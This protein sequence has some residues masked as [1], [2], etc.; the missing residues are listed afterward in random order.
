MSRAWA[1]TGEDPISITAKS[2]T[3]RNAENRII[4]EGDVRLERDGF[5]LKADR[6]E[7][8]LTPL[9]GEG[10]IS[11]GGGRT[12]LSELSRGQDAISLIEAI[13]H[14]E[15]AQEGRQGKAERAIYDHAEEKVILI[16]NPEI[17]SQDYRVRGTRMTFDLREQKNVVENSQAVLYPE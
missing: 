13:G 11:S 9:D 1:V 7:V 3:A 2:M 6:L 8:T 10:E 12:L 14:V 4:F 5:I 16:G 17:W 15:V